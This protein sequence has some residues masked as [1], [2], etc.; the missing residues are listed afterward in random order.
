LGIGLVS[1]LFLGV[2]YYGK[3]NTQRPRLRALSKEVIDMRDG[4]IW[5]FDGVIW[6]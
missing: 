3:E 6:D 2:F 4:I 5:D 1:V